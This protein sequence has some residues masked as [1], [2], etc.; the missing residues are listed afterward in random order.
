VTKL[1]ELNH[2]GL[3]AINNAYNSSRRLKPYALWYLRQI[4]DYLRKIKDCRLLGRKPCSHVVNRQVR[5]AGE[6]KQDK[7]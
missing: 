6:F 3:L 4:K 7:R 5:R 2:I 1:H